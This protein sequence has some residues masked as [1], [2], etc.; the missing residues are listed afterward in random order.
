MG[1]FNFI[2]NMFSTG[3]KKS[4][5]ETLSPKRRELLKKPVTRTR[6]FGMPLDEDDVMGQIRKRYGADNI[7][8]TPKRR[9]EPEDYTPV[10][11]YVAPDYSSSYSSHDHSSSSSYDSGSCSSSYDSGSS[12]GGDCGG[13]GGGGD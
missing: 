2:S 10:S 13:G 6:D 5:E 11:T 3:T 4:L 1:F 7:S 12:G 9:V 8:P